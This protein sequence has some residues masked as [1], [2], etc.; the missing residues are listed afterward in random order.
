MRDPKDAPHALKML[1]L[2]CK[3]GANLDAGTKGGDVGSTALPMCVTIS[4][5]ADEGVFAK[6]LE[7]LAGL[8]ASLALGPT[9]KG[10]PTFLAVAPGRLR[11]VKLLHTRGAAF[12]FFFLSTLAI[13]SDRCRD[14]PAMNELLRDLQVRTPPVTKQ[15]RATTTKTTTTAAAAEGHR[16]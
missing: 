6:T 4:C 15:T 1:K 10:P 2:I 5:K 3:L 16:W 9:A 7:T 14:K 11:F 12:D 8:G 13:R